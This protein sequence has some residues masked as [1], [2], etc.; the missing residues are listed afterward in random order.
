VIISAE[1]TAYKA[2]AALQ[3]LRLNALTYFRPPAHIKTWILPVARLAVLARL[4]RIAER[5]I[6]TTLGYVTEFEKGRH[7]FWNII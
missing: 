3:M 5:F 4:A 7:L 2:K 1:L 6:L